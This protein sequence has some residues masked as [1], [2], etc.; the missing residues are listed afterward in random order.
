MPWVL[1][2][3]LLLS[4]LAGA[5]L[6]GTRPAHAEDH[7]PVADDPTAEVTIRDDRFVAARLTVAVGTTVTW[8]HSGHN[9]HTVSALEDDW[10]S[11]LLTRGDHFSYTFT[12]PGTFPYLCQQ[13]LLQGM[14]GVITVE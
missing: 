4:L 2:T 7:P 3:L 10:S 8:V 11:G 6:T 14:R 13:H 5:G 9:T 12:E 1:R